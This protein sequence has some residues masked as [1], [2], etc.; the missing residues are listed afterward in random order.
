[1]LYYIVKDVHR[2]DQGCL[3]KTPLPAQLPNQPAE[4][5]PTALTTHSNTQAIQP[6]QSYDRDVAD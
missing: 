3:R 1:M 6:G 4:L 2:Q 5:L